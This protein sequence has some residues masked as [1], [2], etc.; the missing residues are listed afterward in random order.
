MSDLVGSLIGAA[1]T[2]GIFPGTD[3]ESLTYAAAVF[4]AVYGR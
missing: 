2:K 3:V 1:I 4:S